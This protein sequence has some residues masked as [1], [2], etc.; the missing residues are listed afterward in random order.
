[1]SAFKLSTD[2]AQLDSSRT[3]I[4]HDTVVT[5]GGPHI[6]GF[7]LALRK[8]KATP[9][10]S[11]PPTP[12][13]T[14]GQSLVREQATQSRSGTY[15]SARIQD[16]HSYASTSKDPSLRSISASDM[17][18][19]SGTLVATADGEAGR[20]LVGIHQKASSQLLGNQHYESSPDSESRADTTTQ[21]LRGYKSSSTLRSYYDPQKIPL[22]ISQQTSNSSARDFALRKGCPPVVS[23]EKY[24]SQLPRGQKTL[25]VSTPKST[26]TG[27]IRLD[28]SMLFPKPS[29]RHDHLI[30]SQ[31]G[32][33]PSDAVSGPLVMPP[34]V[35][36]GPSASQKHR[37]NLANARKALPL[38]RKPHEPAFSLE[39]QETLRMRPR[40]P[41]DGIK[42]WVD[43]FEDDD[44]EEVDQYED[45]EPRTPTRRDMQAPSKMMPA[46]P[47]ASYHKAYD[48][49]L[50]DK[51]LDPNTGK[52]RSHLEIP[53]AAER[54][55]ASPAQD[56]RRLAL[57]HSEFRSKHQGTNRGRSRTTHLRKKR[58]NPFDRI[59]VNK[60]SVLCL[61]SS[62]DESEADDSPQSDI[63]STIPGIRDSLI[64][65][66]SDSSDV[67]IGTA[68]AIKTNRPKLERDSL[69]EES[70]SRAS[71]VSKYSLKTVN[72]PERHSSRI[73]SYVSDQSRSLP[74]TQESSVPVPPLPAA[75]S[76]LIGNY[77]QSS[78]STS[79]KR[80]SVTRL[81]TVTPQEQWLLEAIRSKQASARQSIIP[82]PFPRS[83]ELE[84]GESNVSP[85][86]P[87]TSGI[88]GHSASFFPLSQD[89]VPAVPSFHKH[90][91]SISAG[92]LVEYSGTESR[93]SCSIDLVTSRRGSLAYSS[94]PSASSQ[95]Y[96]PTPTF[97]LSPD[98][99]TRRANGTTKRYSSLPTNYQR[100]SR[101]RTGSSGVI[102][103]DSPDDDSN[104][105]FNRDDLPVWV[106][107]G[108]FDKSGLA[109]VH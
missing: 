64:I 109:A 104:R 84:P 30:Q 25:D 67:E 47:E 28:L 19:E 96:P 17:A 44:V 57:H 16:Q 37:L 15:T 55:K 103:L 85:R 49:S 65:E 51:R 42:D 95:E 101:I 87:Q 9:A 18:T 7:P 10:R 73:F 22:S 97:E 56:E 69:R 35:P 102:V 29:S 88:G 99:S 54:R 14:S 74:N 66:S 45:V 33:R 90:R 13:E 27:L 8:T 72:I 50:Q 77:R 100:H 6:F 4:E 106:F 76:E 43:N 60:D 78:T 31:I 34:A 80:N 105:H 92:E 3:P 107:N 86:R 89:S 68:H 52:S 108:W 63:G 93:K 48:T 20:L 40:T 5:M 53:S 46:K 61:S 91:R 75:A 98:S 39:S 71:R 32:G 36:F 26:K 23:P 58:N 12:I 59:D 82:E 94:L 11:A 21:S 62:D 81:M 24:T 2:L 41:R 83:P 79:Q 70:R 38:L 1:M